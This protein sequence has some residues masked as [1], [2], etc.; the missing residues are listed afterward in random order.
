MSSPNVDP[1]SPQTPITDKG[2]KASSWLQRWLANVSGAL[3]S[4]AQPFIPAASYPGTVGVSE[5]RLVGDLVYF[6]VR[7]DFAADGS[8][9]LISMA[10]P[11]PAALLDTHSFSGTTREG[12]AQNRP[13]AVWSTDGVNVLV[14]RYDGNSFTAG[15]CYFTISGVYK[16]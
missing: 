2:D 15:P 5:Y 10:L 9:G 1:F 16:I 6:N 14:G 4:P 12:T 8:V 3:V 7:Y 13:A 11:T